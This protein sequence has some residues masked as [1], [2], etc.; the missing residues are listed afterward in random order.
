V[1]ET[2]G[3]VGIGLV[4]TALAERLLSRGFGVVGYDIVPER[5]EQLGRLGGEAATAPA[6]VGSR[7]RRVLLS[8]L[9]S[10]VVREVIQ[11]RGGLLEAEP[12]PG[13]IV[14]TTTG[15]P[16]RTEA[17]AADLAGRGVG[18]LDAT[19]AGSSAQVRSGEA[20]FMVGGD[21]D[22][23]AAAADILGALT[24]RAFHVGPAGSGARMKLVVNLVLGLNR[25]ALA[26]G[27]VFAERLGLDAETTLTLLKA[28]PA[29][30]R[31]MD[32]KGP[33][34]VS[35]DFE[36]QARLAQHRKDV[37]LI[38]EMAARLGQ[39]LPLSEVHRDVL[40]AAIGAGDGD[41]DNSA[42]IREIRRGQA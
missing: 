12:L 25:L 18:Y 13:L 42:L 29:Y 39:P 31:M 32:T 41:L 40:D 22:H 33:K 35:G 30:S 38:L 20:V 3:L 36:P 9:T 10:D 1:R 19:I 11:G 5:C 14:D 8:L 24:D 34:M 28:T 2:V 6:E 15:D 17:I 26:E 21:E 27:L 7:A 4:G 23:F 16:E 37:G